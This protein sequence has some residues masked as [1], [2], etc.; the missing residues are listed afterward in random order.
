MILANAVVDIID[1]PPKG[2]KGLG[3]FRVECWGEKPNDYTRIYVIHAKSEDAAA[4]EG[5][6]TFVQEI[7]NMI[8]G[9]TFQ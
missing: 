7:T 6:D 4:H 8:S 5:I 3:K 9:E 1:E 2:G